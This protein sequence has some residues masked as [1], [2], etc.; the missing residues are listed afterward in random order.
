MSRKVAVPVPE[1]LQWA[2]FI[3]QVRS[4]LRLSGVK[5]V[6]LASV[7]AWRMADGAYQMMNNMDDEQH[8]SRIRLL[9]AG[10]RSRAWTSCRT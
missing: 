9:R 5:E 3:Q 2:D 1:G 10:T 6:F 4:K 7:G 8:G